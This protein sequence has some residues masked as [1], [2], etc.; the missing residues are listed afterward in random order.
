MPQDKGSKTLLLKRLAE[1]AEYEDAERR[2]YYAVKALLLYI[3]D[4][5][6]TVAFQLAKA[7][8]PSDIT[9]LDEQMPQWLADIVKAKAGMLDA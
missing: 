7:G 4:R 5:E 9:K 8:I 2:V 6:I 3:N 1:L